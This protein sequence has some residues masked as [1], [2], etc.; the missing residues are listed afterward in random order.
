MHTSMLG[1]LVQGSVFV[2]VSGGDFVGLAAVA[3]GEMSLIPIRFQLRLPSEWSGSSHRRCCHRRTQQ[4]GDHRQSNGNGFW[5]SV[6]TH[7]M[8]RFRAT[9]K[10]NSILDSLRL[11][12]P[13]FPS[14]AS[15]CCRRQQDPIPSAV[16]GVCG[17]PLPPP[18][19]TEILKSFA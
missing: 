7:R 17:A 18:P 13:R 1:D 12:P 16:P 6:A 15:A 9:L 8:L 14:P 19:L 2:G 3:I 11:P 10:K 4:Q 5:K